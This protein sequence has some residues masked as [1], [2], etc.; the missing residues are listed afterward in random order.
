MARIPLSVVP[1]VQIQSTP[2]SD[3]QAI[4]SSP[5]DF[6]GLIGQGE[7]E[8]SG[9]LGRAGQ[10]WA[11]SALIQ[12]DR[13]NKITGDNAMNQFMDQGERL[14]YGTPG[15]PNDRGLYNLRG[16][17]A[18]TK[19][20]QVVTSL[21]TLRNQIKEGLQNDAQKLMF[22][23][24]SRRYFQYKSSEISR[25]LSSQA[26]VYGGAVNE[27]GIKLAADHAGNTF[28]S[29]DALMHSLADAQKFSDQQVGLKYGANPDPKL[30]EVGQI[31]ARTLVV[32]QAVEGALANDTPGGA[33]RAKQILDKFGGLIDPVMRET[34]NRAT[35]GAADQ[36]GVAGAINGVMGR[37]IG[38]SAEA[39]P[40]EHKNN[41]DRAQKD[42]PAAKIVYD[43]L[44][45]RGMDSDDAWAF[46]GNAVQESSANPKSNPGDGG[47]AHGLFMWRH[48]EASGARAIDFKNIYGHMPE[49]GTLDEQLDFVMHELKGK[50]NGAYQAV[51]SAQGV[52]AKARTVS[53]AY[54][55]PK[56]T[57]AEEPRRATI[58]TTLA[59]LGGSTSS[60]TSAPTST[61]T[62]PTHNPLPFGWEQQKMDQARQAARQA[63]PDDPHRQKQI[64]D[65]VWSEIEKTNI[66]NQK[67]QVEAQK[68]LKDAQD[69][70]MNG[71]ITVLHTDPTKFDPTVLDAKDQA[72]N[73][74]LNPQ[75]REN[76]IEFSKKQLT[77]HGIEDT[78]PYGPGYSKAYNDIIA[79]PTNPDKINDLSE[80][81]R[82]G[83]PGGELTGL[84]VQ[85]LA[86]VFSAS[87][88]SV[89]AYANARSEASFINYAKSHLSFEQLDGPIKIRDPKGEDIFNAQFVPEFERQLAAAK[90]EAQQKND[91]SVVSK[92]LN[93]DN[94]DKMISGMRNEAQMARDR[95]A[96]TG[97]FGPGDVEKPGTPLPL[98][99]PNPRD[100][101]KSFPLQNA[102]G[103]VAP[104]NL[105]PWSRPVLH[106]PDGSYST[107][108]SMSIGTDKGEVLIPTV[109]NGARLSE[110][111][112]VKHYRDTGENLGTFSTPAAADTYATRLHNAQASL[113][114]AGG[115]PLSPV[116]PRAWNDL[117][118]GPLPVAPNGQA[119]THK[120]WADALKMLVQNPSEKNIQFFN[121]W[122]APRGYDGA[123]I[124][125]RLKGEAPS[126][127]GGAFPIAP[128][129]AV[130]PAGAIP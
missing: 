13:F 111:A 89:D 87:R 57:G 100:A 107:T 54:L 22:D 61:A 108:S 44:V 4:P 93:K 12:Q 56:D 29:D 68:A 5:A 65:G 96:A 83:R 85:K 127:A 128:W 49:Q 71:A 99:P 63:F 78:A 51:Q 75:Q 59:S 33:A 2:P 114:D 98:P 52:D 18:L 15:D 126:S 25:H 66:L 60:S 50:E 70:I 76:I 47:F 74:V 123:E 34:L 58:A 69:G 88:K 121:E 55:R 1:D 81:L 116:N 23:E 105:D 117:M 30:V 110:D 92:F 20:P 6:G 73:F 26:D 129:T 84:G 72:G 17:E 24:Q 39:T 10:D 103:M 28:N 48:D 86:G 64:T 45:K 124:V 9:D 7:K 19:G 62:V 37:P 80:I 104:G 16:S 95:L 43:G 102:P 40:Q 130:G 118:N 41:V 94:I 79:P 14:T 82:R 113:Y 32:K 97:Q 112:A 27:A 106:N 115:N 3:Y 101:V 38:T 42:F 53:T 11:Q 125:K 21:T 122:A 90:V 120:A 35:K 77:E 109:V 36:A 46:A 8:L 91:P 67:Y 119:F 31:T